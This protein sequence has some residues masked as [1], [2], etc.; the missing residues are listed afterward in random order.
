MTEDDIRTQIAPHQHKLGGTIH[1]LHQ[2]MRVYGYIHPEHLPIVADVFNI[3][4][5][6]V[7]GIISFYEDF[8][9]HPPAATT[10]RICQAEA[11]QAVGSRELTKELE[12]TYQTKLGRRGNDIELEAV[13][14]LGLCATGPAV[15]VNDQLIA[16]ASAEK[17]QVPG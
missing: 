11:C 6:E 10:I 15:Q 16:K 7:R 4:V 2:L 5:A 9:T 14:C 17:L 13:Y 3:S 8:K 1:A 12:T